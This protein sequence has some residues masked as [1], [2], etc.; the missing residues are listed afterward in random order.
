MML[1]PLMLVIEYSTGLR[2]PDQ[3]ALV[4]N[5]LMNH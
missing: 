3:M 1:F 4:F 2:F 5:A